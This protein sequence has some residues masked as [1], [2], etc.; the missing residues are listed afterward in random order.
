MITKIFTSE[1]LDQNSYLV[2]DESSKEGFIVDTPQEATKLLESCKNLKIKYLFLTH[3]HFDH[4]WTAQELALAKDVKIII[5]EKDAV[6]INDPKINFSDAFGCNVEKVKPDI[7]VSGGESFRVGDIK[8]KIIPTPGHTAGGISTI[9]EEKND[10]FLFTGDTLFK[11]GVG[12]T[13]LNG[14]SSQQLSRSLSLLNEIIASEKIVRIFPG[15]GK[16]III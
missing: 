13:D 8:I 14:G 7:L 1:I 10:K 11:D 9:A 2:Y 3:N 5:G 12:R 16:E 6:G 4:I 15:H